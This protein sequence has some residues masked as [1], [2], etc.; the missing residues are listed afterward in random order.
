MSSPAAAAESAPLL[1][2]RAVAGASPQRGSWTRSLLVAGVAC[3][4]VLLLACVLNFVSFSP[5]S[6]GL[7]PLVGWNN[8]GLNK[9]LDPSEV[10]LVAACALIDERV[11][12]FQ[13]AIQS[14]VAAAKDGVAGKRVFDK[15]IIVDWS[16]TASLWQNV[17]KFW[18]V[19][20]PL[21]FYRLED[22]NGNA[23]DWV[24]AKAY[25]FG[26]ERVQ[27][28]TV[29]KVD[30]DTYLSQGFLALNPIEDVAQTKKVFRYGDYRAAQDDNEIHINGCVMAKKELMAS[31]NYYDERL[32]QYGWDDTNFYDR[33]Q[34]AG[35]M[36]LNMTR[37]NALGKTLITHVWHPHSE[38]SQ[39]E[40]VS[41][42][43]VNRCGVN[44][45]EK[46]H[47]WRTLPR[48]QYW[49]T[50]TAPPHG[51]TPPGHITFAEWH[52]GVLPSVQEILG[53]EIGNLLVT[54][55]RNAAYAA[56]KCYGGTDWKDGYNPAAELAADA[57][58]RDATNRLLQL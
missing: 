34:M 13:T 35:A 51:V 33:L 45:L 32:Q 10:T 11:P 6:S 21:D 36:P 57:G 52:G 58:V 16:S 4:C 30:C 12:A 48:S 29:L 22:G 41:T 53:E 55:C 25:N 50:T 27:T 54:Y 17:L 15:V 26:L 5:G 37:R 20:T 9:E 56:G 39:D 40:R 23:L 14:W 2:P 46:T 49:L 31:V 1:N 7:G 42:S 47:P 38:Q 19:D 44:R 28:K 18:T 8:Y 24:L 43:C 3:S